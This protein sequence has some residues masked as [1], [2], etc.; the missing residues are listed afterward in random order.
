MGIITATVPSPPVT[1]TNM[2][3]TPL[4]LKVGECFSYPSSFKI[5]KVQTEPDICPMFVR[6]HN[7]PPGSF[8]RSEASQCRIIFKVTDGGLRDEMSIR[9]NSETV[10]TLH[11]SFPLPSLIQQLKSLCNSGMRWRDEKDFWHIR[12]SDPIPAISVKAKTLE[13]AIAIAYKK[14]LRDPRSN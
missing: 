1:E 8:S 5:Y 12:M 4:H 7:L 10:C 9:L 3:T 6:R 13:E 2:Q 11:D 14:Y